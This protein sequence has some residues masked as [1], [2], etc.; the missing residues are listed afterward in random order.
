M[1]EDS[2][3][4]NALWHIYILLSKRRWRMNYEDIER[5]MRKHAENEKD[6]FFI[7]IGANDGV[8]M[9]PIHEKIPRVWLERNSG[10]AFAWAM[11]RIGCQLRGR[12][13]FGLRGLHKIWDKRPT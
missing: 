1:A 11:P 7:Q 4:W 5:R 13:R 10:R 6:S 8:M 9:D 3:L 12:T 2:W